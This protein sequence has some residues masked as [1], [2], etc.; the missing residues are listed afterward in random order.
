MAEY[1]FVITCSTCLAIASFSPSIKIDG[2]EPEIPPPKAPASLHICFT[3]PKPGIKILL[4]GSMIT[5]SNE[6]PIS[7]ISFFFFF[8]TN[9]AI[10]PYCLLAS[11][12]CTSL[13][14]IWRASAVFTSICGCTTVTNKSGAAKEIISKGKTERT[15]VMPP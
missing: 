4:I 15:K 5:S 2:P 14:K 12:S 13:R 9:P 1:T 3:T 10:L 11:F 6:R 8:S 7:G